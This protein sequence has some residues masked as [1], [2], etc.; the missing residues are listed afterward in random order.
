MSES[1]GETSSAGLL[2]PHCKSRIA[3]QVTLPGDVDCHVDCQECGG[4]FRVPAAGSIATVEEART[5]GRFQLLERVG[6]GSFGV[7]WRARDTLLDRIIALKAPHAGLLATPALL[8][9]SPRE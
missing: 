1:T 3:V 7:V 5:L 6:Q 4:S 8:E 2:C 9:R